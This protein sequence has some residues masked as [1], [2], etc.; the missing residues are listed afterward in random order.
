MSK[1]VTQ[2]ECQER[3]EKTRHTIRNEFTPM[4]INIT[5][6]IDSL[7]WMI[8]KDSINQQLMMKDVKQ[9]TKDLK[10]HKK[11][12]SWTLKEIVKSIKIENKL[13]TNEIKSKIS[14]KMFWT[15]AWFAATIV[16]IAMMVNYNQ[17]VKNTENITDILQAIS[18]VQTILE[19]HNKITH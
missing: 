12:V 19:G 18:K 9:N 4:F 11:E 10:E 13:I 16:W 5:D 6:S 2:L 1:W 15:L 3:R 17:W 14:F 8:T 7:K